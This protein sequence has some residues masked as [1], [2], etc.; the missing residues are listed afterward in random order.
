MVTYKLIPGTVN[1][2]MAAQAAVIVYIVWV[3]ATCAYAVDVSNMCRQGSNGPYSSPYS[4]SLVAV[5]HD[6][7]AV[8]DCEAQ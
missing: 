8:A 1:S 7:T 3:V 2:R 4:L 6:V 5:V